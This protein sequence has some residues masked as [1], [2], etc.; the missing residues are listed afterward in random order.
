MGDELYHYGVLGMKWGV[1]R[2]RKNQEKADR[3][4]KN[5]RGLVN[6]SNLDTGT[7]RLTKASKKAA[8]SH[9]SKQRQKAAKYEAK[10]KAIEQ[11]HR[12]RAGSK[13]Y[14]AVKAKST[15]K[16][17]AESY[18]M[19]TYGAL[20]YEQ[21]RSRGVSRGKAFLTGYLNGT[22]DLATAGVVGILEPR[23][24]ADPKKR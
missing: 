8:Y 4:R 24:N 1:H 23:L 15:G 12:S 18:L 22:V 6:S 19:G 2:A 9:A 14:D 3:L 11:K 5:A 21:A 16:L 13:T 10:A 20:K 17:I 7:D